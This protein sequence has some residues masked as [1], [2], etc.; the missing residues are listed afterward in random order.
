MERFLESNSNPKVISPFLWNSE[1]SPL[2]RFTDDGSITRW[3]VNKRVTATSLLPEL[4]IFRSEYDSINR[5]NR[6]LRISDSSTDIEEGDLEFQLNKKTFVNQEISFRA[7]DILAVSYHFSKVALG[8]ILLSSDHYE[9]SGF[10]P[11]DL[12]EQTGYDHEVVEI[13]LFIGEYNNICFHLHYE[14]LCVSF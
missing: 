11:R 6:Y 8:Q 3:A 13:S 1:I 9:S 4:Q 10:E 5:R 2:L 12:E 14:K 7:G